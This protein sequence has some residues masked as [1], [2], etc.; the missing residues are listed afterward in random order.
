M[1]R[2]I[3]IG[4]VL[5]GVGCGGT[6]P[7]VGTRRA[8]LDQ[9]DPMPGYT[10]KQLEPMPGY[11]MVDPRAGAFASALEGPSMRATP[12]TLALCQGEALIGGEVAL[13]DFTLGFQVTPYDS[14][15]ALI[16]A[17][18]LH[19]S[20]VEGFVVVW[21]GDRGVVSTTRVSW[22]SFNSPTI[23]MWSH[24][25]QVTRCGR[26]LALHID[27]APAGTL[28]ADM[29]PLTAEEVILGGVSNGLC[30][31]ID[32]LELRAEA[33]HRDYFTPP[34]KLTVGPTHVVAFDFDGPAS[35][36]T[37]AKRALTLSGAA[38]LVAP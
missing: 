37:G 12:R 35:D 30:A 20:L 4:V 19:V 15:G 25:V 32:N 1:S 18:S 36:L 28:Y 31:D 2:I 21:L 17:G 38:A 8:A 26:M 7:E 6:A 24:H 11:A 14:T 3:A 10:T 34:S 9:L 29:P 13:D 23:A 16:E 5:L 27:G 33:P 22:R